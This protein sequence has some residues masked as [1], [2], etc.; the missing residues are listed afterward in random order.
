MKIRKLTLKDYHLICQKLLPEKLYI[1]LNKLSHIFTL[2]ILY[3]Y[4]V[5]CLKFNLSILQIMTYWI[6]LY[7]I[8]DIIFMGIECICF[9]ICLFKFNHLESLSSDDLSNLYSKI[10]YL[11][12]H[13]DSIELAKWCDIQTDLIK[14]IVKARNEEKVKETIGSNNITIYD[15]LLSVIDVSNT[16]L[17]NNKTY[18]KELLSIVSLLDKIKNYID[19]NAD[20][21][22]FI[23]NKLFIYFNEFFIL[24]NGDTTIS[25]SEVLEI[26]DEL[27]VYLLDIIYQIENSK[28]LHTDVSI[29]VLLKELKNENQSFRDKNG[30]A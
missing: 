1:I 29:S 21:T 30:D 10:D 26:L 25:K 17:N 24:M 8:T 4:M 2:I 5:G 20:N 22:I 16:L 23:S 12:N 13:W 27:K 6:P 18:K 3:L 7:I 11:S 19:K 15:K 14:T 9:K 28:K